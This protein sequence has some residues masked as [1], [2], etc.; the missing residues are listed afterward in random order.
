MESKPILIIQF[1]MDTPQEVMYQSNL[2]IRKNEE[3]MKDYHAFVA[4]GDVIGIEFKVLNS[5]YSEEEF[6]RL[7]D[8]IEYLKQSNEKS[9]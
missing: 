5:P 8:L 3:L 4:L 6:K 1:P 9:N 7:E 2:D